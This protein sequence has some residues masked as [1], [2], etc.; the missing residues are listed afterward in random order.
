MT[1]VAI[2]AVIIGHVVGILGVVELVH[3]AGG[4]S[5]L[6][7]AVLEN[8][9]GKGNGVMAQSAVAY[10]V[11][12]HTVIGIGGLIVGIEMASG[13]AAIGGS[14]GELGGMAAFAIE[15][16]MGPRQGE[17]GEVMV[18]SRRCPG[19]YRMA[20]LTGGAEIG[21]HVVG[22]LG[23]VVIVAVAFIATGSHP[24]MGPG[25]GRPAVLVVA[26]VAIGGIVSD[27]VIPILGLGETVAA[28]T[29]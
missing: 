11:A 29:S 2:G 1:H 16:L 17:T 8:A 18:V 12:F 22:I 7:G 9:G 23:L 20:H 5:L 28:V 10:G 19:P 27:L 3:M 6:G 26:T 25:D 14:A 4:T 15:R 13:G 21:S 24:F